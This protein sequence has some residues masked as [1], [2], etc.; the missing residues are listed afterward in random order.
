M[1]QARSVLGERG[2]WAAPIESPRPFH[3]RCK[4]FLL[5]QRRGPELLLG[6][7]PPRGERL[8]DTS[9]CVVLRPELEELAERCRAE[10]R[11]ADE[12]RSLMLRCN[13]EGKVQLTIA[14]AGPGDGLEELVGRIAPDAG[15]LQ[16][17]DAP[18]NRI[19]SDEEERQV[20]GTGPILERFEDSVSVEVPPTAFVQGNPDVAE[21][22]YRAAAAELE[23]EQIGEFYCGGGAAGLLALRGGRHVL[24]HRS[25]RGRFA[26]GLE[27]GLQ[28]VDEV[29]NLAAKMV[30]I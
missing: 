9:G 21:A 10:V 17:H 23:G 29:L 13:R 12:F 30:E 2:C 27:V 4:T 28:R 1:S 11:L 26:P 19:C 6:A 16:P 7:R 20:V 8:V 25:N 15:F 14:H 22:L 3:Y 24:T 5:P 18:G